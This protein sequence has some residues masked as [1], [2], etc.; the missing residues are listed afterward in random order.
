MTC[1][2]T[3]DRSAAQNGRP[4]WASAGYYTNLAIRPEWV[5][6]AAQLLEADC[7]PNSHGTLPR[8]TSGQ[9]A[10]LA[11][12]GWGRCAHS[13]RSLSTVSVARTRRMHWSWGGPG[14]LHEPRAMCTSSDAHGFA[15]TTKELRAPLRAATTTVWN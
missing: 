7:L 1:H 13:E 6:V 8:S 5:G 12:E 3:S 14:G 15:S 9:V 4:E 11:P 2:D 10:P